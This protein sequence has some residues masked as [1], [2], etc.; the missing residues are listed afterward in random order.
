MNRKQA[1]VILALLA[2][3]VCAGVLAAKVNGNMGDVAIG[4]FTSGKSTFSLNKDKKSSEDSTS[5]DLYDLR[6]K[7]DQQDAETIQT[8]NTLMQDKNIS[9]E[10]IDELN[11]QQASL[12]MAQDYE[13]RIEVALKAKGFEDV[14][15]LI[16]ND[17]ARI[18]VK[19]KEELTEKDRKAIQEVV[20]STS[21]IK[22]VEI[23]RK[24]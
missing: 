8:L 22:N 11:K 1:G 2:L 24:Q 13:K 20:M 19:S 10:R 15:C 7:K 18:I 6:T 3:I 4:D 5:A 14:L 21:K 17:K 16:E 9:K 12:T 23:E